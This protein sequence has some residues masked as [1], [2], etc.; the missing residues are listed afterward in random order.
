MFTAAMAFT[1]DYTILPGPRTLLND[2]L[3]MLNITIW[4][5]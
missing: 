4:N 3:M 2:E 5:I 1:S